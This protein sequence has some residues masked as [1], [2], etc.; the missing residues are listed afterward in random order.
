MEILEAIKQRRSIRQFQRKTLPPDALDT[1]IDALR[2]APSAGNL[3]SRR[4]YFVFNEGLKTKLAR[5]ALGQAFIAQAPLAVVACAD[6]RIVG[7]YGERGQRL[8]SLMD[9]AASVQNLHLAAMA[10]GLGSCWVGAFEEDE[11]KRLLELPPYLRP[12]AIIPVGF[13]AEHPEPPPRMPQK[14]TVVFVR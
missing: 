14:D 8:Y 7:H 1:L 11:V 2:W 6:Q 4:F 13:A 3:E 9:V 10:R 12:V 5:A